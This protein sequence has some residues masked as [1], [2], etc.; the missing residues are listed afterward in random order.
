L[1]DTCARVNP[2]RLPHVQT[3]CASRYRLLHGGCH[4]PSAYDLRR[5]RHREQRHQALHRR[6]RPPPPLPSQHK[7]DA[8]LFLIAPPRVCA[9]GANIG[10][11]TMLALAN[12]LSVIAFEPQARVCQT[13]T[14]VCPTRSLSPESL[15]HA[16]EGATGTSAP[17]GP[18][19]G[20]GEWLPCGAADAPRHAAIP[21]LHLI[22]D[23]HDAFPARRTA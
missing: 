8:L 20:R 17:T 5:P 10:Y 2:T 14:R 21:S 23:T 22:E 4:E 12:G 1:P 9:A 18:H 11:Y 7:S 15:Q 19:V 16:D 13:C 6:R 3:A